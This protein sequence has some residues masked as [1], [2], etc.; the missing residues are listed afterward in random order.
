[1]EIN[2]DY[3]SALYNRGTTFNDLG[4]FS[5]AI[6]DFTQAA[7]IKETSNTYNN[8]GLSKLSMKVNE[9]AIE[10]FD[11]SIELDNTNSTAYCNRGIA[12]YNIGDT[13]GACLDW[14]KACELGDKDACSNIKEFCTKE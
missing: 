4:K 8:R 2:P 7:S 14:E 9:A 11:K 6:E 5:D 10:D 13:Q 1:L 12:R 3:V